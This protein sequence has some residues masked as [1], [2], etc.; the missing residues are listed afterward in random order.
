MYDLPRVAPRGCQ[1][2]VS[3]LSAVVSAPGGSQSGFWRVAI[4]GHCAGRLFEEHRSP[5]QRWRHPVPPPSFSQ[6]GNPGRDS[7]G[8]PLAIRCVSR[9]FERAPGFT[10]EGFR[11]GS[12]IEKRERLHR[13][14]VLVYTP[15]PDPFGGVES[16]TTT[17]SFSSEAPDRRST[18]CELHG[19]RGDRGS[20]WELRRGDRALTGTSGHPSQTAPA[21]SAENR[22]GDG[23]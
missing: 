17:S 18:C 10:Q 14:V 4:T 13:V 19:P 3:A 12:E 2:P 9:A 23:S 15:A 22:R 20:R 1:R 7:G 8:Y 16:T 21:R 5:C 11:N 6:T